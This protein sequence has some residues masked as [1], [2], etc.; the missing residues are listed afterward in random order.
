MKGVFLNL[1]KTVVEQD[2]TILSQLYPS[3]PQKIKL[4]NEVGMDWVRR[5]F[6]SWPTK[7]EPQRAANKEH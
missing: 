4:N 3:H 2:A 6:E 7:V 1:S 5:N